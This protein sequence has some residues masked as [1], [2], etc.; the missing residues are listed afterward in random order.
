MYGSRVLAIALNHEHLPENERADARATIERE[1][2]LRA[3]Y[4]LLEPLDGLVGSVERFL[5]SERAR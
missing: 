3:Y 5:A 2:A 1:T 4:P